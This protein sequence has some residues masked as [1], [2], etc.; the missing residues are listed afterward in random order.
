MRR[1]RRIGLSVGALFIVAALL[2]VLEFYISHSDPTPREDI[3]HVL[4]YAFTLLF[5]GV[6]F[7]VTTASL[8]DVHG[9]DR[10]LKELEDELDLRDMGS[11]SSEQKAHKLLRIQQ[12]QLFRYFDLIL[13]QSKGIFWVGVISMAL[14]FCIIG[15][16]M[17]YTGWDLRH[18]ASS[19]SVLIYDKIIVAV[20]GAIG[21]ILTNFVAAIYLKMFSEIVQSVNRSVSAM[22]TSTNL[23]F[24]NVLIANIAKETTRD[25]ALKELATSLK[26]PLIS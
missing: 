19:D 5:G 22:T 10:D 1:I 9:T 18:P 12:T 2:V 14:G 23:N 4:L 20:V 6:I 17:L 16:T 24:A 11:A 7:T 15:V 8:L 25:E 3:E 13:Q 21:A 26:S